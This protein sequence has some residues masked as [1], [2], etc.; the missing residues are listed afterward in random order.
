MGKLLPWGGSLTFSPDGRVRFGLLQKEACWGALPRNPVKSGSI[1]RGKNKVR[2]KAQPGSELICPGHEAWERIDK[3]LNFKFTWHPCGQRWS[4]WTRTL[5]NRAIEGWFQLRFKPLNRRP[6]ALTGPCDT[7]DLTDKDFLRN[8]KK[9]ISASTIWPFDEPIQIWSRGEN[10]W[11]GPSRLTVYRTP[12]RLGRD[13]RKNVSIEGASNIHER[14]HGSPFANDELHGSS[15]C[16]WANPR[17][18]PIVDTSYQIRRYKGQTPQQNRLAN[19]PI[20]R[21]TGFENSQWKEGE[22]MISGPFSPYRLAPLAR[23]FS[24]GP[25][26]F[27]PARQPSNLLHLLHL[28]HSYTRESLM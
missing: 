19:C 5:G 1:I 23:F 17:E 13:C 21:R 3:P 9:V 12:T 2:R 15:F 25:L 28:L 24:T 18:G 14:W 4:K 26:R 16:G 8:K 11:I 20:T 6:I 22:S 10:L 7:S 27:P